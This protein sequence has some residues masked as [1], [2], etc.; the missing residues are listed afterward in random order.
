MKK[1]TDLLQQDKH[2][3]GRDEWCTLSDLQVPAI[4]AKVDTGATTSAIHAFNIKTV[5]RQSVPHVCFDIHP[6]QAN[7]QT[8]INCCRPILD[9]RYV[10]S[11]NG[12]KE[13]RYVICTSIQVGSIAWC[14]EVTLSNRDPLRYRMLLG[15]EAMKGRLVIDPSLSC[16]QGKFDK[17]TLASLYCHHNKPANKK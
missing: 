9:K 12:C 10:M 7:S 13:Y 1:I 2:L 8:V 4:K 3:I 16:N 15:Q 14:I 6:L 5:T 17:K 11:S